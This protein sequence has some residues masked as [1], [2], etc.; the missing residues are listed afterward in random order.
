MAF[1]DVF[2]KLEI[3]KKTDEFLDYQKDLAGLLVSK[4][5]SNY[6]KEVPSVQAI[7]DFINSYPPLT[8]TG[9]QAGAI[10]FDLVANAF[11]IHGQKAQ[12]QFYY[13]GK[14]K[15]TVEL[16]DIIFISTLV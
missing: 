6:P 8:K 16:A 5:R 12:V 4:L 1:H 2:Q 9:I 11:F 10:R 7:S 13:P 3:I 14:I 15:G